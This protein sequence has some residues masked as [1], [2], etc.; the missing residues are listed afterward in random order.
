MYQAI[1]EN[2]S[3][4]QKLLHRLTV[5]GNII[6]IMRVKKKIYRNSKLILLF[7]ACLLNFHTLFKKKK[8]KDFRSL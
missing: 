7:I 6:F 2:K 1:H 4:L 8:T 5:H 3:E